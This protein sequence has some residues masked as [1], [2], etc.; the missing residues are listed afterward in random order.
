V[1]GERLRVQVEIDLDLRCTRRMVRC[2]HGVEDDVQPPV[3]ARGRRGSDDIGEVRCALQRG[4]RRARDSGDLV[5]DGAVQANLSGDAEVQA[6]GAEE[7]GG[8]VRVVVVENELSLTRE[9]G[10][11]PLQVGVA[12]VL[13]T[14]L[15]GGAELFGEDG[16]PTVDVATSPE[17]FLVVLVEPVR[18]PGDV[19]V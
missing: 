19:D 3:R 15:P 18:L 11:V 14:G 6:L 4:C 10:D 12:E 7:A 2:L 5:H 1:V 13:G 16:P 8:R 17:L 9:V